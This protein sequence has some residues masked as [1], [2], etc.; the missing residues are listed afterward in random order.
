[1][2]VGK[3]NVHLAARRQIADRVATVG[4]GGKGQGGRGGGVLANIS[5]RHAVCLGGDAVGK[6][7]RSGMSA[8]HS[9]REEEGEGFMGHGFSWHG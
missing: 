3:E 8:T 1:M 5:E 2:V 7:V 4:L 6:T 9:E